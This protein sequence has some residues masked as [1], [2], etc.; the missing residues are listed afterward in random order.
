MTEENKLIIFLGSIF[1]VAAYLCGVLLTLGEV[2]SFR[3]KYLCKNEGVVSVKLINFLQLEK[4]SVAAY[5]AMVF[6]LFWCFMLGCY[7][8]DKVHE[9]LIDNNDENRIASWVV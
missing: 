6:P 3:Q 7:F 8:G 1:L 5:S 4:K 9:I 2:D